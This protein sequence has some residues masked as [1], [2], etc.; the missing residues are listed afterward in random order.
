MASAL[1][2]VRA[3][4]P[5]ASAGLHLFESAGTLVN[6]PVAF[7]GDE[8]RRHVDRTSRICFEFSRVLRDPAGTVPLKAA[9][10]PSP[11]ELRTVH[12]QFAIGKPLARGD[13]RGGWHFRPDRLRHPLV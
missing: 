5:R 6:T 9:L 1:D 10:E 13:L 3:A 8:S 4:H 12:S 2:Q 11:G 7:A